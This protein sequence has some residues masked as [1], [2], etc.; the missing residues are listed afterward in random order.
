MKNVEKT[1]VVVIGM[2]PAGFNIV[3][4]LM[5]DSN[6]EINVF[7]KTQYGG[8]V[9]CAMPYVL[10]GRVKNADEILSFKPE[11]Y[12]KQNVSLHLNTEVTSINIEDHSVSVG[13][14]RVSYDVLVI[15]TGRTPFKA[16]IEG[17]NLEGVHCLSWYNDMLKIEKAMK[18]AKNAVVIG[19]GFIGVEMAVA[20]AKNNINTTIVVS[21]YL[22]RA[23]LDPDMASIIENNLEEMGIKVYTG[24]R[25]TRIEGK[26][27]VESVI[28]GDIRI[29][30]DIVLCCVGM[31]PN[32]N[33][34]REAGITLGETGGIVTSPSL[35][36][37]KG[38]S[39]LPDVYACGDC[40]E[41]IDGITH[42]PIAPMLASCAIR[43]ALAIAENVRGGNVIYG[44]TFHPCISVLH[45]YHIGSVGLTTRSAERANIK[46]QAVKGEGLSHFDF[47]SGA[48]KMYFKFLIHGRR[49][50]GVQIIAK[51]DVKQ[52]INIVG[53][54]IK[55]GLTIDNLIEMETC[56]TPPLCFPIDPMIQAL[57]NIVNEL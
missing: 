35:H 6:M 45:D 41:L 36:V 27:N 31:R 48:E 16:D 12:E 4:A 15:A 20:L 18:R 53:L 28:A 49:L 46:V 54:S 57:K 33:L 38:Q 25:V 19:A 1:R 24:T 32:A 47:I 51:E 11:F 8:Y 56:F 23:M 30:A 10:E 13:E 34:A 3:N 14:K 40:I 21:S 7:E 44:P 26:E 9:T 42:R 39:Y 50:I 52:R 5:K 29:P 22:L 37:K 2:G 17:I 55:H 43:Q